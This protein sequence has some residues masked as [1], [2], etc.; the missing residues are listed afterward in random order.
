MT[1]FQDVSTVMRNEKNDTFGS[2]FI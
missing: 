1:T 2:A